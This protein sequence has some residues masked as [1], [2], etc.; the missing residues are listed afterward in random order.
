MSKT[1]RSFAYGAIAASISL[2]AVATEDASNTDKEKIEGIQWSLPA[3]PMYDPDFDFG[4]AAIPTA[5][6][7]FDAGSRPSFT[8]MTAVYGSND[9]WNLG[10]ETDYYLL[11]DKVRFLNYLGYTDAVFTLFDPDITQSLQKYAT[12]SVSDW[13]NLSYEVVDNVHTGVSWN[14]SNVEMTE[15]KLA[16]PLHLANMSSD[17]TLMQY[18]LYLNYSTR[19]NNFYPTTG[20]YVDVQLMKSHLKKENAVI[21]NDY[22][23]FI[24]NPNGKFN[25]ETLKIDARYYYPL[26]N[27]TTL[28]LRGGLKYNTNEAPKDLTVLNDV[29]RDFQGLS[30]EVTARSAVSGEAYVR[31]W[32]NDSWGMSTG[33]M[34]AQ[35]I[36][37][38]V[39]D[40]DGVYFAGMIG[41][42]YMLIPESNLSLRIDL[43]QSN[44]KEEGTL[45]YFRVGEAF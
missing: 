12:I 4:L 3:G 11:N 2:G 43:T 44:Q 22:S 45:L 13:G 40:Q 38:N 26:S 21:P 37:T 6:H 29:V 39:A 33:L 25:F 18:G 1:I 16:E 15:R 9:N 41:I 30:R 27:Q 19:D 42:R 36:D 32:F 8:K 28:A 23:T 34:A 20:A 14:Y 35:G 17:D 24:S 7:Q 31:H 10:F 5:L